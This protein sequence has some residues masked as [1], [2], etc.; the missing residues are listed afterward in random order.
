[1]QG[2]A[3]GSRVNQAPREDR[4]GGAWFGESDR[5]DCSVKVQIEALK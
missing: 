3:A 2:L 5:L 1:M 4:F